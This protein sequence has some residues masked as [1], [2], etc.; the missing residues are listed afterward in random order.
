MKKVFKNWKSTT[1]LKK[2]SHILLIILFIS[3]PFTGLVL[4]SFNIYIISF[5]MIFGLYVLTLIMLII[6]RQWA[7][8]FIAT[9]GFILL[10]AL[11]L[12][13]SE[14]LWYLLKKYYDIDI[15]YR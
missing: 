9:L 11:T 12:G 10:F 14:I 2:I 1:C 15:S 4:E 3:I 5:N 13:L 7:L 6:T 8:I